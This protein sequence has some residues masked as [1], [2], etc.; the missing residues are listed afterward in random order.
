M[1]KLTAESLPE[2]VRQVAENA[3]LSTL[4][5]VAAYRGHRDIAWKLLPTIAR[6]PFRPSAALC[7][8]E[9]EDECAER[10]LLRFFDTFAASMIPEWASAGGP[11]EFSWNRLILAQHHGLPTRL[12]DW[13]TNPLVA[14]FFAL[15]GDPASCALSRCRFCKGGGV[16]DSI[17]H[18]L[19]NRRGFSVS[20]LVS[21]EE[22]RDA[23]LYGYSDDVGLLWPPHIN[24][25]VAAQ[26]S[27]FAIRRNP[28]REIEPDV[29]IAIPH[30]RRERILREL[31]NHGV[32]RKTL[33]PDLEGVAKY[34]AWSCQFWEHVRGVG[35]QRPR[36][37]PRRRP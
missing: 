3:T 31:E 36:A 22:N 32:T 18:A 26:S 23:P 6:D 16:H 35:A 25:R 19:L 34:L 2:F 29:S 33:F 12:L 14:L 15:E 27:I 4:D 7:S 28:G 24:P 11:K 10:V 21:K 20:A 5:C 13:T 1:K 30:A 37:A 17:V 8:G 9:D